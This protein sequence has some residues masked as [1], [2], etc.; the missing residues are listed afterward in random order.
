MAASDGPAPFNAPGWSYEIKFDGWRALALI[1][2]GRRFAL[3]SRN[4]N[5]L[6]ARFPEF[7]TFRSCVRGDVL[8]DGEI[9]AGQGTMDDFRRLL[10]RDADRFFVA[11]DVLAADGR[12]LIHEPIERRRIELRRIS[13]HLRL[14]YGRAFDDGP[15]L[16]AEA[17][18][19]GFEGIVAKRTGSLYRP[20]E[21][22]RD[23]IKVKSAEA[24]AIVRER[25]ANR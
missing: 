6:T 10:A 2:Q 21:R 23:W 4:G 17:Q 13:N 24:T 11:F 18:A 1:E 12:S 8:L 16:F 25:F 20:G 15:A 14:L 7:R 9:I 5:D 22:S 19:R 3:V